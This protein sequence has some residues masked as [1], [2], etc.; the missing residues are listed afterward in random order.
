M[1]TAK[2]NS[3]KIIAIGL[4]LINAVFFTAVTYV[5]IDGNFSE[6]L[7]IHKTQNLRFHALQLTELHI[8]VHVIGMAMVAVLYG[9]N[10]VASYCAIGYEIGVLILLFSI[11]ISARNLIVLA[12]IFVL[13]Y[14]LNRKSMTKA[15]K[16]ESVSNSS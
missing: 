5:L 6:I 14:G 15:S 11:S 1:T 10:T 9:K 2:A 12:I 16:S 7:T 3:L 13:L 8:A 4:H